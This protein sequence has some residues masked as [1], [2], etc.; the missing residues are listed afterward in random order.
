MS[1]NRN[2]SMFGG[3]EKDPNAGAYE[4]TDAGTGGEADPLSYGGSSMSD[5]DT[6]RVTKLLRRFEVMKEIRRKFEPMWREVMWHVSPMLFDF[7]EEK[8]DKPYEIPKRVTN[9]PTNYLAPAWRV[10]AATR[11]LRISSGLSWGLPTTLP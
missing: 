5:K 1:K 4:R 2:A 8:R 9:K 11:C 6:E 7:D 10:S 3:S